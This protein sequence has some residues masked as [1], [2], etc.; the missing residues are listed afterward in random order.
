MRY[1]GLRIRDAAT[2]SKDKLHENKLLLY[3]L[4]T[5]QP[6]WLSLPK[7]IAEELEGLNANGKYFFWSGNGVPKSTVADWQRS[8]AK[9][10]ELAGING[11][12]HRFRDTFSVN[13]LKAGV[14]LETVSVLLGHSSIRITER[15]Y[16]PWV[17]FR[18]IKLEESIEKA[19][20]LG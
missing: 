3:T 16:S 1:S 5:G 6:V 11:H 15:H 17:K 14:P 2:L 18:Q 10:F 19:W 7:K 12:A 8:L 9:V 13:L 4:K 20:K